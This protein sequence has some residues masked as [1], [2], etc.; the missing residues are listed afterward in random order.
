MAA[1]RAILTGVGGVHR[2]IPPTGPCCLVREE[3][4]ELAPR[5]VMNTLSQTVVVRHPV[6]REVF[7]SNDI[8]RVHDM[9]A[10]PVG[11]VAATPC[12]ALI[13]TRHDFTPFRA[14]GR[15]LLRFAQAALGFG[16][17]LLLLA[18]E[19]WV[20]NIFASGE[21]GKGLE[22]YV[23][24]HLV[25]SLLQWRRLG[26]LARK[27]HVPLAS[28]AA[29]DGGRLGHAFQGAMQDDLYLPDVHHAQVSGIHVQPAADRHLREGDAVI[30]TLPAEAGIAW[31][32]TRSTAAKERLE[33][34]INADSHILQDLRLH[35]GK[36]GALSFEGG[37]GGVLVIEAQRLPPLLPSSATFGQQMVVQP[38]ALLKLLLQETLL[39]LVRVQPVLERLTHPAIVT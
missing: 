13:D 20:G 12:D 30:A 8:K 3:V 9:P 22:S 37:Q 18:E 1:L 29:A 10:V 15:A 17:C 6:D 24:A 14:F 21:R 35:P 34:E 31:R 11:E 26:T 19:A 5:R 39:L 38:A 27:R 33:G 36:R 28:A 23:N 16:K 4:R 32:L 2:D 25:S 7:N